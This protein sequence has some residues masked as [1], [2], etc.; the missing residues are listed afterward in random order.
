M[1][2]QSLHWIAF[3][4]NILVAMNAADEITDEQARQ[5][6]LDLETCYSEFNRLLAS[7]G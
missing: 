4:L 5:F 1:Q 3:R 2:E 7:T 6:Q